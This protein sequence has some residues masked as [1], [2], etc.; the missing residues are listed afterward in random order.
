MEGTSFAYALADDG[1]KA[2]DQ[3]TTQYFEM[4][5]NRGIYHDGWMAS[6]FHKV[7]WDTG[8]SVPF[9]DDG[10]ELYNINED[11]SQYDDL[12]A[13]H[14]DKLKELQAVFEK[15][16]KRFGVFPLDDRLAGRLDVSLRPSWTSARSKFTFFPG[17]THLDEGTAPNVKNKSHSIT[18]EVEI[19]EKGAEG[20][21][22]AMGGGTGGYVLYIQDNKFTY[23]YD[24]FGYNDY[25]IESTALPTG[26]VT[27]KMDFKYDGGGPG[28]GGSV[29]LSVNGKKAG[30]GR[31]EKTIPARFGMDT[32]DVGMDLNAPVVRGGIYK[33]PN[34]FTGTIDSV[35]IDLKK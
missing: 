2:P 6:K 29:T 34:K 16:G 3:K 33:T 14:P 25:K 32:F 15:E 27:L 18:A 10:W 5:G 20:V 21:L 19:S 31:V 8:S 26:K 4:M 13:T 28:K 7:P 12:A 1:A 24:F 9:S 23:Y 22:L 17:L 11:F 35:T 30:E